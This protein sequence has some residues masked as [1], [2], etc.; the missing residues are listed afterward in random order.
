V[1]EGSVAKKTLQFAT[2]KLRKVFGSKTSIEGL[3]I[4]LG[5]ELKSRKFSKPW[6]VSLQGGTKINTPS[7]GG[8]RIKSIKSVPKQP[9]G[10]GITRQDPR[11]RLP[12]M[13]PKKPTT[14]GEY[15]RNRKLQVEL[16][17]T[18]GGGKRKTMGK[19]QEEVCCERRGRSGIR[20]NR[21]YGLNSD[22]G[23][24]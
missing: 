19:P 9:M 7:T 13:D 11:E 8:N 1:V 18:N 24:E 23:G 6:A 2:S 4:G 10:G 21:A 3:G 22:L 15:G 14:F 16:S 5:G 17:N 20:V 12:C